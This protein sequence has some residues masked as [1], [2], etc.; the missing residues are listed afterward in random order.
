MATST[1]EKEVYRPGGIV[2][3]GI[4]IFNFKKKSLVLTGQ[5][6][7]FNIFQ[8]IYA[9]GTKCEV[10]ILDSNGIIEM[11]PIVGDETLVVKFR[12][13]TFDTELNYVFKIY[14][15]TSRAKEAARAE[16]FVLHGVSQ[17]VISD[18]RKSLKT[19]YL[20]LKP[21]KIIESIYENYLRPTIEEFG[22]IEDPQPELELQETQFHQSIC[23][24]NVS[25]FKA[26]H[27][28]CNEAV[29]KADD[30]SSEPKSKSE[31]FM[32]YQTPTKWVFKTLDSLLRQDPVDKFY[33]A[34]QGGIK[35]KKGEGEGSG[36]GDEIFPHQFIQS[37]NVKQ[38]LDCVKNL[39]M[40]LYSHV[41]KTIDPLLKIYTEDAWSWA[42]S[43][44]ELAH[45]E[46]DPKI[47]TDESM[48]ASDAGTPVSHYITSN[49]GEDYQNSNDFTKRAV[50]ANTDHQIT[51]PRRL[52]TFLKYMNVSMA[53][54]TN[55]VLEIA[56][57]GN[58]DV[59][60]GNII[61]IHVPQT[62][63]YEEF[64]KSNNL[65]YGSKF[66]VI[67]IRHVFN[68]EQNNFGTLLQIVKDTYAKDSVKENATEGQA[69]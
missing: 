47:F 50:S 23:F 31:N 27:Q 7:E 54:L 63:E 46:D 36:E 41:V 37:V 15:I 2:L 26:I 39:E 3:T 18:R 34:D 51:N 19:S 38:Q 12:T 61:E 62:S 55:I 33:F 20:Q 66:L 58:T 64:K 48:Y 8:D 10:G 24:P 52:H 9:Q 49:I 32:F 25:P 13:P 5:T 60:I 56:I 68:R 4:E 43:F 35:T 29:L 1:A 44:T 28:I 53:Q 6:V 11:L 65:L 17:E 40:G 21:E 22:I 16:V 45:I 30:T 42:D 67:A 59:E 69:A 14:K 57:S